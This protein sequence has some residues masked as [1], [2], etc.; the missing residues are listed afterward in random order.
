MNYLFKKQHKNFITFL[1]NYCQNGVKLW[2]YKNDFY[3]TRIRNKN[4]LNF[5]YFNSKYHQR[6]KFNNYFIFAAFG[7][8]IFGIFNFNDYL[9]FKKCLLKENL[10]PPERKDL[11]IF[12]FEEVKQHGKDANRIWVTYKQGVYDIT[13]FIQSHPGGD[14]I[15]LAA[16]NSIE[17]YWLIYAQHKT[18]EVLEL[19]EELRIGSLSKDELKDSELG[20]PSPNDPFGIDPPR[21]PALLINSQKPF[22]AETPSQLLIDNFKTPNDLFFV[23]NHMPVPNLDERKHFLEVNG[24]GIKRGINLSVN[25][26]KNKF[27]PVKITSTIQCAG[28]RRNDMNKFKKVQGL[29]WTGT[30]ISNAEWT[31]CRLRDVLISAGINP[32]DKEIKH[33]QFEG[34]DMDMTANKYGASIPFDKAMSPEVLIAYE[35]NGEPLPRD[36]GYPLRIIAPGI[37]G[38]RQVKWLTCIKTSEEESTSHWQRKDY[39]AMPSNINIGDPLPFDSVPSI[40]EYPVQSA[41]CVPTPNTKISRDTENI[42]VEG[43]A[44]SGGGRGIIRVEVSADGGENWKCAELEQAKGQDSEHMWAWTLWRL[45]IEIPEKAK[46]NGHFELICK[47]T[48]R[49]YNTQ[50]ED[51]CGIWN[52]RGLLHNAWHRVDVTI[53]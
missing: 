41:I 50:P 11:P 52:V 45:E 43:Y 33:V 12:T 35:M 6:S 22:N 14:K 21:H 49:G 18:D 39:K 9:P 19:L 20:K 17:P 16:G 5:D 1:I 36:H 46:E 42:V 2:N 30:A 10:K 37:V 27:E 8:G 40:Q 3:S 15:L 4:T 28:N 7:G 34:A 23:R 32:N 25:D 47:A 26:L 38:A 44:W 53:F 13:D 48:D 31:G 24:L 29:M 51:A